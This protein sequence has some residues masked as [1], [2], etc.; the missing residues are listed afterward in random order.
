[1]A[2]AFCIVNLIDEDGDEFP[3]RIDRPWEV[4]DEVYFLGTAEDKLSEAESNGH[5]TF[6]GRIR[7]WTVEVNNGTLVHC[8]KFY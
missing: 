1:M 2:S 6:K 3:F 4:A 7:G 8:V 5:L